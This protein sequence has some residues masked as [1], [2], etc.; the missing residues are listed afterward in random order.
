MRRTLP[1][2]TVEPLLRADDLVGVLPGMS[3]SAIYRAIAAGDIPSVRVGG[4][5]IYVPNARLREVLQLPASGSFG[6]TAVTA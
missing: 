6:S 3:R 5:R 1:D 4:R 2:P